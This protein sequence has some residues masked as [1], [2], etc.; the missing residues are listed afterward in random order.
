MKKTK[1]TSGPWS[2]EDRKVRSYDIISADGTNV[3]VVKDVPKNLANA[4]LIAASPTLLETMKA[5]LNDY[6]R[7]E[8][9]NMKKNIEAMEAAIAKTE[10]REGKLK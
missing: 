8:W 4:R 7:P 5:V 2:V 1:H 9:R 10:G 6:R 3:A